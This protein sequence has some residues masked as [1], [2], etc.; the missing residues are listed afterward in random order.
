MSDI[1]A[2]LNQVLSFVLTF[3]FVDIAEALVGFLA[4]L[5]IRPGAIKFVWTMDN[6]TNVTIS[7]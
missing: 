7:Y 5:R 2:R 6:V 4:M 3:P 1:Q